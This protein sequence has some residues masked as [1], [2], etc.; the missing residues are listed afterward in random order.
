VPAREKAFLAGQ[1]LLVWAEDAAELARLD[2]LLWTFA[3]GSFVPHEPLADDPAACE[4]PVQLTAADVLP[5][6]VDGVFATLLSLRAAAVPDMLRFDG[7]GLRP[8]RHRAA[9]VPRVGG[10]RPVPPAGSGAPYCIMIPPPNVTGTLH[11]G[12]AF[13]DTI[14]DAL[15]R[16]HRMRGDARCGRWAPTM[17]ASRRRWWSS[18]SSMPRG[19]KPPRPGPRA[20]VERVWEW[21]AQSGGTIA[22]QLRRLGASVDWSANASRWTTACRAPSPRCS[23]ACTR[24]A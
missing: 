3:D 9:P 13:Q 7:Q 1:R 22:Q 21:K 15:I 14:M 6:A 16:Y 10:A 11:M 4:S 8:E 5:P 17:P 23:C 18:A 19:Q 12:H 2:T 20:F 24:K